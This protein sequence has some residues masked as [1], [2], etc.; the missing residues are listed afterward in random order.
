[1]VIQSPVT[2]KLTKG[3]SRALTGG[4]VE[5]E[6]EISWAFLLLKIKRGGFHRLRSTVAKLLVSELS[7]NKEF[8]G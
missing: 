1:M 6:K 7:H 5:I 8:I 2:Q 4:P 3:W